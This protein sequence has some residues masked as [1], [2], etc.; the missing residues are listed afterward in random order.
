MLPQIHVG[1]LQVAGFHTLAVLANPSVLKGWVL[2]KEETH[3]GGTLVESWLRFLGKE[4][5]G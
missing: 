1:L 3:N 5:A 2:V 4:I